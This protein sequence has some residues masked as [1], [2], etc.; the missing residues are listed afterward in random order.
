[1]GLCK[2]G[3]EMRLAISKS[4]HQKKLPLRCKSAVF[5]SIDATV[6][7]AEIS[8][9]IG[10]LEIIVPKHLQPY[11]HLQSGLGSLVV[12]ELHFRIRDNPTYN[13]ES[14]S[15]ELS[16][17]RKKLIKSLNQSG[18]GWTIRRISVENIVELFLSNRQH[19][20]LL[21]DQTFHLQRQLPP[22]KRK[23]ERERER[24]EERRGE[25]VV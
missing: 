15:R 4:Q 10:L 22:P 16:K 7:R 6:V 14:A 11:P 1:M 5:V 3:I 24:E 13:S 8:E 18:N 2:S 12:G 25:R 20:F 19:K 9:T 17:R 23:R 21:P